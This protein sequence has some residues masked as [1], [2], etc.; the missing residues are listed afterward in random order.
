MQ[1]LWSMSY[2]ISLKQIQ[3]PQS[4]GRYNC[5]LTWKTLL[6]TRSHKNTRVSI[7]ANM[8][9]LATSY[10]AWL[11]YCTAICTI[12]LQYYCNHRHHNDSFSKYNKKKKLLWPHIFL[13]SL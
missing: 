11:Q 6:L 7:Q 12:V 9:D 8:L 4:V 13:M 2:I 1:P 10:L 3:P 5:L